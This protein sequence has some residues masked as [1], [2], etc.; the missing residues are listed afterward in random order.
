M[1]YRGGESDERT[2]LATV[3]LAFTTHAH[4]RGLSRST[5]F[6]ALQVLT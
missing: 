3:R 1:V 2:L 5:C 4:E 6:L